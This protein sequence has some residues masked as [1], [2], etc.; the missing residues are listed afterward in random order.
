M[1]NPKNELDCESSLP[2]DCSRCQALLLDSP[3]QESLETLE[4]LGSCTACRAF[5]DEL[6]LLEQRFQD[7]PVEFPPDSAFSAMTASIMKHV[8]PQPDAHPIK[9]EAGTWERLASWL[10]EALSVR[11]AVLA[12]AALLLAVGLWSWQTSEPN[13]Q[14]Q[15]TTEKGAEAR[16]SQELG[17]V[18][19]DAVEAAL[20]ELTWTAEDSS[21]VLGDDEDE[22]ELEWDLDDD[23]LVALEM[24]LEDDAPF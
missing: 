19:D 21:V 8:D 16:A 3:S 4:H 6:T 22:D 5:A 9:V 17:E 13:P 23:E 24:L 1:T 20:A 15:V 14:T 10:G 12:L 7:A 2:P 18:E 11:V